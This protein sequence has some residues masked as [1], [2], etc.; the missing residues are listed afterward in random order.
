MA[1]LYIVEQHHQS[2][3]YLAETSI[4]DAT[5]EA[6][7]HDLI[8]DQFDGRAVRVYKLTDVTDQFRPKLQGE[9]NHSEDGV[10]PEWLANFMAE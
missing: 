10:T 1:D 2:G 5:E 7:I 6:T 8:H 9:I 3:N 4:V